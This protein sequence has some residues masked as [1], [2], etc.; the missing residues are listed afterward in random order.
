MGC[1]GIEVEIADEAGQ[2]Q[3]RVARTDVSDSVV[4]RI[5]NLFDHLDAGIGL[6]VVDVYFL[7]LKGSWI[8]SV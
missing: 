2:L 5:I 3:H 7:D 6:D 8:V 4:L 1:G